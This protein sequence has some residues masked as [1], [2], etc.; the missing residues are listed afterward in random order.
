MKK[1]ILFFGLFIT[2]VCYSQT[3]VA[4]V[5]E[6]KKIFTTYPFSDPNPI[7]L[8]SPVYPYFRFDGF[9]TQSE[10]KE[11]KVVEL[12]NDYIRIL[13]LPEIGG[14]IWAA[15]EKSTGEPFI[16][17]NHAVKFR[18]IAMRGPWTSGGLE[19]NFGIIGHTPN[20]ATPVDY[21]VSKNADGSASCT[22]GSLDLLSR[23]YWRVEINL[24][25]DK[26]YF[27]THAFWYNASA[28]QEPYYH[29]MNAGLQAKGN[30]E[31]VY[32]GTKYLGHNGEHA[33]WPIN[34]SNGKNISFYEQNDFGGP[35]SYHVFGKLT[36][37]AGAFWH[38]EDR[39]MV[40][41]GAYDGKPGK[42]IW[43]WGLSRQGMIWEKL[44]TDTDGQYVELQSGRRFNQNA[45]SSSLSPFK[46]TDFAPNATDEWKEY[47]YPVLHTK[48][49]VDANEYGAL[50]LKYENGWLKIY[51]SP[52]QQINDKIEIKDGD[53]IV[54]SKP[55]HLPVLKTFADSVK[56][57]L[58]PENLQVVLGESKMRYKSNPSENVL[59]RPVDA[60][61]DFDW[62]SAYGL[63]L[64]GRDAM[65]GKNYP[66][67]EIKLNA[68][69]Q[70]D[71]NHIPS[72]VAMA[73][74]MYRNMRYTEALDYCKKALSIDTYNP[75]ANYYYGLVNE[76]L[77]KTADAIDGFSIASLS[78]S[79]RSAAYNQLAK[80]FFLEKD[81]E[82]ALSYAKKA[83]DFNRFDMD[84]LQLQ[85]VIFRYLNKRQEADEL[86]KLISSYDPLNHFVGFERYLWQED[87]NNK[88][89]FVSL[90][91][92]ELPQE[93]FL[94]MGVW[95]Y[96]IQCFND[97]EKLFELAKPS[98]IAIYWLAFL[99]HQT[100]DFTKISP[101]F[102]FP[103]R[104]ETGLM[105]EQ[106]LSKQNNWQLKYQLALL[107]K[108]RN[109]I[110]ESKELLKSCG[111]EPTF[112][113]FYA[114]RAAIFK[115]SDS[116]M[117]LADLHRALSL[118]H[119]WRYHKLISEYFIEHQQYDSA[120]HYAS[121]I[122]LSHPDQYIMGMLYAKTLLLNKKYKEA[123]ALLSKLNIIPFEGATEGRELYREA[124]LMQAVEQ[125]ERKKYAKAL[126]FVDQSK[127]WP[128]N[129]GVGKPY[130]DDIDL[131]L[132]YWISYLVYQKTNKKVLAETMLQKII[133]FNPEIENTIRNF[134]PVNALVSAWAYEQLG[135]KE[136]GN[137]WLNTQIQK[138][139]NYSILSWCQSVFE[140]K[141]RVNLTSK[142]KD[143]NTRILERLLS[144]K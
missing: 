112:A 106:L 23:S 60:P 82:K 92:N 77:A 32:P 131:R 55:L 5:R 132:E 25:K 4:T 47:W 21:I 51:F 11:W 73:E 18:D 89:A 111:N 144:D 58:N 138:Y 75:T 28:T 81:L 114:V 29:W 107:Y 46:Q 39:G 143:A 31:F 8:L 102:S 120:L 94:E 87:G 56:T 140:N 119:Q 44:L 26:A 129:L 33:N 63:Y 79:H 59:D 67:A 1:A 109:R 34:K 99:K 76:Q 90:V 65:E 6:Y 105:M 62:N 16:Y 128:E 115:G 66:E 14:K 68:S 52:V 69:L 74:L 108:D 9:T 35:K 7:P 54:Y 45:E 88:E 12:E 136:K 130:D 97:A 70:K 116:D 127:Q 3:Q 91:K 53:R 137:Q 72:L 103:F 20:C 17:Y 104:S 141:N 142:E 48:G 80:I 117:V 121:A 13:I 37:F 19:A 126:S 27:T 101:D 134:V 85:S 96:H 24:P 22:I 41:Y 49:F 57:D 42:K 64:L 113:P 30:L 93:T 38:D 125:L 139:P 40:R 100:I 71:H 15:I 78:V 122:Y 133:G 110:A 36:N 124:K 83:V 98:P 2:S 123:D 10:P 86:L 84:A 61:A 135:Q 118:D 50:N 43:I 95:Y